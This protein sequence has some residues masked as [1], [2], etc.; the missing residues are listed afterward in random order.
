M[1]NNES[2]LPE[3]PEYYRTLFLKSRLPLLVLDA[4]SGDCIDCND[5]AAETHGFVRR[6]ELI[7]KNFAEVSAQY[8]YD[9][10]PSET[11]ARAYL[12]ECVS[13]GFAHFEWR[14][15]RPTGELWD[16]DIFF[17]SMNIP[18][19]TLIQVST[20][21]VTDMKR[22]NEH[23]RQM[24]EER[25]AI[26][27]TL[28]IGITLLKYR[29]IQWANRAFAEMFG[30]E[31]SELPGLDTVVFYAD[32]QDYHRVGMNAYTAIRAD[33][34]FSTSAKMKKKNGTPFTCLITGHA[35]NPARSEEGSIWTLQDV[36][37]KARNA[38]DA[39]QS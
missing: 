1:N 11:K 27:E 29:K 15:C 26:L 37:R 35:L 16:A 9:G 22:I 20:M 14:Q 4:Y 17:M 6:T 2:D 25:S 18:G 7:G 3:S 24:A 23:V 19:R 10:A 31:P 8:Q 13:R 34:G 39:G 30:Y 21:D 38:P 36:S 32:E 33:T 12:E 5:R 28:T